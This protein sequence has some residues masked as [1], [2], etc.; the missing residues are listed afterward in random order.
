MTKTIL[1]IDDDIDWARLLGMRLQREGYKVEAAFD[2][3]QAVTRTID[4]KPDLVLLDII[5]PA[6]TGIE[7]L[8]RLRANAKTFNIPVIALTAVSDKQTKEDAE[9]LGISGYFVKPVDTDELMEKLKEVL[10]KK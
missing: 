2:A 3:V 7:V 10:I 1:I 6:G 4:L 5:M 8:Q 9:K